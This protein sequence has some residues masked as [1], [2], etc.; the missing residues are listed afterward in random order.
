MLF[1]SLN[2]K[3]ALTETGNLNTVDETFENVMEKEG[4]QYVGGYIAYKFS[5]YSNLGSKITAADSDTWISQIQK[6]QSSLMKPSSEFLKQLE[7]MEGLFKCYHG[8][9]ELKPGKES[10]KTV[11]NDIATYVE[12][13][14]D[15]IRFFVR[16]RIF[17][18]MRILNRNIKSSR[19]VTKKLAKLTK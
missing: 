19:Q 8:E 2:Q 7:E 11:T 4:L 9:K 13:P 6:T 10:V 3:D 15:V 17:F 5:Q 12:L 14:L 18:R 1:T 16:C